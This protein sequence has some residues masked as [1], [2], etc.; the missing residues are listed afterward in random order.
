MLGNGLFEGWI[1]P[2]LF[3]MFLYWNENRKIELLKKAELTV[4]QKEEVL[5][6][7][8]IEQAKEKL[9]K[10]RTIMEIQIVTEDRALNGQLGKQGGYTGYVFFSR[11]KL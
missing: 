9:E 7:E 10:M 5:E 3:C 2:S 11:R 6:R 4:D 1:G 8:G